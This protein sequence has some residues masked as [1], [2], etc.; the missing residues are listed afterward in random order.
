MIIQTKHFGEVEY[1]D[2]SEIIF[3]N[4]LPGFPDIKN[5]IL[6]NCGEPEE[7]GDDLFCY[8]QCT[9]DTDVAFALM[10]VF[11]VL[12]HYNPDVEDEAL[13]GLGEFEDGT[14]SIFNIAVI[15]EEIKEMRVN[16]KAPIIINP[17]TRRGMQAVVSNEEYGIRH[18]IFQ[19]IEQLKNGQTKAG[20]C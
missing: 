13:A 5:F 12:P 19:E 11:P 1:E 15:P 9:D 7:P 3:E 6:I 14:L 20:E 2:G 16:L 17:A 18:Y 8:L 10:N 4:G